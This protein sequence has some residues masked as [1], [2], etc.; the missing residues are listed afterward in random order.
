[1]KEF[2]KCENKDILTKDI[3]DNMIFD[4]GT[5]NNIDR[6]LLKLKKLNIIESEIE[7]EIDGVVLKKL[8]KWLNDDSLVGKMVRYLYDQES[9]ITE[10]E[11]KNGVEYQ[12]SLEKFIHSIDNGRSV[13]S[14]HGLLWHSTNNNKSIKLN[15]SR[16]TPSF[17]NSL[18]I[19]V[20]GLNSAARPKDKRE[21]ADSAPSCFSQIP[22]TKAVVCPRE[23][24]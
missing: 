16:L 2:S 4:E 1:M 20:V 14:V 7:G 5:S 15:E 3:I 18:L 13:S 9:E 11:F 8:Q 17:K 10:E 19:F 12:G 22:P 24:P 23:N 6:P 21:A